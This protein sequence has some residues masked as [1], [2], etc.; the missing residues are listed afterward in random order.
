MLERLRVPSSLYTSVESTGAFHDS[1]SIVLKYPLSSNS[2]NLSLSPPVRRIKSSLLYVAPPREVYVLSKGFVS[3]GAASGLNVLPSSLTNLVLGSAIST[4]KSVP[5]RSVPP[6]VGSS[7]TGS[8]TGG[9]GSSAP[10]PPPPPPSPSPSSVPSPVASASS[11]SSSVSFFPK[12]F[13]QEFLP[14]LPVAAGAE[15]VLKSLPS[16]LV[17]VG[18]AISNSISVGSAMSKSAGSKGPSA[19]PI[20]TS[21]SCSSLGVFSFGSAL[22]SIPLLFL[23]PI[24]LPSPALPEPEPELDEVPPPGVPKVAPNGLYPPVPVPIP[25]KYPPSP[26]SPSRP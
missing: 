11:E 7:S 6:V 15:E 8:T 2:C 5:V 25:V 26:R 23:A 9:G 21:S 17:A 19:K 16:G 13:F 20:S 24:P 10:S 12:R 14:P 18:G 1:P 22:G 4:S 3:T